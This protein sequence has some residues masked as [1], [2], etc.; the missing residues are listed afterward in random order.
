[1]QVPARR[2]PNASYVGPGVNVT[3]SSRGRVLMHKRRDSHSPRVGERY[4]N[5]VTAGVIDPTCSRLSS[6]FAGSEAARELVSPN[7]KMSLRQ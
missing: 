4:E 6:H 7:Q 5:L 3:Q 1:M 2:R